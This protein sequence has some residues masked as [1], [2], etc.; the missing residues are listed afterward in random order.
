MEKGPREEILRAALQEFAARG[1]EGARVERVA[2]TASV[3]KA[4]LYYYFGSKKELYEA[5][6]LRNFDKFHAALDGALA[7]PMGHEERLHA[8]FEAFV[9]V[10]TEIPEHPV[11]MLREV[12]SGGEHLPKAALRRMGEAFL[13]VRD[14]LAA[15]RQEGAFRAVPPLLIHFN[16]IGALSFLQ[17]SAPL[18]KKIGA[19]LGVPDFE[20]PP[21]RDL[22]RG[23]ADV[24][25]H[26]IGGTQTKEKR[27]RRP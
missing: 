25:L 6:L 9:T 1:F 4:M 26:G 10:L 13:K 20:D 3:N 21:V 14:L 22:A 16:L 15:G 18:R 24:V 17:A 2:R 7:L 8:L 19:V 12:A 27:R 23:L 11:L 5:V